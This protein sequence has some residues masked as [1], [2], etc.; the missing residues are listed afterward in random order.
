MDG[1]TESQTDVEWRPSLDLEYIK[2]K[3][4]EKISAQYVKACKRK[5]PETAKIPYSNVQKEA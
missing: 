3:S 4:Y 5:V 1:R 2:T